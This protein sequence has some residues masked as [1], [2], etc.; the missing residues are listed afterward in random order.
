MFENDKLIADEQQKRIES[1]EKA[2]RE[3]E[4]DHIAIINDI[5]VQVEALKNTLAERDKQNKELESAV[6]SYIQ[7]LLDNQRQFEVKVEE[8]SMLQQQVSQLQQQVQ[9]LTPVKRGCGK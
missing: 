1:L 7:A 9:Q 2:K 3:L 8:V 6:Q 5:L 4:K